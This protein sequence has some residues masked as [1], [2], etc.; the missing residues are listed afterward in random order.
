LYVVREWDEPVDLNGNYD[1][2]TI[3]VGRAP[4]RGT[5]YVSDCCQIHQLLTGIVLGEQAEE[6]IHDDKDKQNGQVDFINLRLQ[7]KGEGN[8]SR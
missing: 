7:F 1:Y 6:W 5:T 2:L 8:V 4:L 3:L